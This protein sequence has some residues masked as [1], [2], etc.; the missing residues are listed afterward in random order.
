MSFDPIETSVEGGNVIELYEFR[1]GPE[2]FRFT[3]FNRDVTY[4]GNSWEAIPISR[5]N[6]QKSI[7]GSINELK[8]RMPLDNEIANQYIRNVPGKRIEC[9]VYRGHFDDPAAE[10]L[11][12]FEGFIA[13][14]EFDGDLQAT[15][16]LSPF[17]NVF[18]RSGPRFNYQGL[19]NNILYDGGCKVVRGLFV[20]TGIV[21]AVDETFRTIT[22][23][24]ISGQGAGWS[25]GGFVAFPSGGNDDQRLV[26]EQA[27]DVLTLLVNFS[28]DVLNQNVD[29][30][31][32]CAHDVD[33]CEAKFNNLIN[34]GGFPYVPSKNPYTSTLRGG[35]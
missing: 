3:S 11:I 16:T 6:V 31:A 18:K 19:C 33:T 9:A 20:Y 27:G 34:Y 17:T 12:V 13:Q 24:G 21:S 15:L 7:E 4:G 8:I 25:E 28:E 32:G 22:V 1:K 5:D 2:V 10:T 35:K 23:N 29:V 30:F 26:L 14:A